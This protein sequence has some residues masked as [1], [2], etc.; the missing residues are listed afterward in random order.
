MTDAIEQFVEIHA[1]LTPIQG[2]TLDQYF[3]PWLILEDVFM[4]QVQAIQSMDLTAHIK[5][6]SEV[7]AVNQRHGDDKEFDVVRGNIALINIEGTMTKRGSSFGSSGTIFTRRQVRLANSDPDIAGLFLRI[8]SPGGTM[9]G[10]K[11]LADDIHAVTKNKP[12]MTFFED[13]GASAAFYVGSQATVKKA[14]ASAII[15]SIGTFLVVVDM[16]EMAAKEGIKVHVVNTGEFKGVGI[17]GTEITESHLAYLQ[18]RVMQGNELF[19]LDVSRGTNLNLTQVR[20][21][22]D[23][24]VHLAADATKLGL[25]DGV[26]TM[27][28]ALDELV[29]LSSSRR[30]VSMSETIA[31]TVATLSELKVAFPEASAEFLVEQLGAEA[32]IEKAMQAFNTHLQAQL[33]AANEAVTTANAETA[34]AKQEVEAAL[35]VMP[36]N[37][38]DS[39]AI[40]G[41]TVVHENAEA[42]WKHLIEEAMDPKQGGKDRRAAVIKVDL[43]N[44]GLR[45][46]YLKEWKPKP[47]QISQPIN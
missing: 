9:G 10:T 2:P 20:Q 47:K 27:D 36:G 45:D 42:K 29:S 28:E 38:A 41:E 3:G 33:T 21:L 15:G 44:P 30:T 35:K 8:D 5:Q 16:S 14:N 12:V 37:A 39:D 6:A 22:A 34:Q 43:E 18:E 13:T 19:L 17:P 7:A 24:R 11:D 26:A 31:P 4:Q 23:G 25:I 32:T 46:Q 1:D 40:A